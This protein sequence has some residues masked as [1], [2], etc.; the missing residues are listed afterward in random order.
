[1][2][3]TQITKQAEAL[4]YKLLIDDDGYAA[5]APLDREN[6]TAGVC[7][8]YKAPWGVQTTSYGS[9]SPETVDLVIDGLKRAQELVKLLN[10]AGL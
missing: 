6:Y 10:E 8:G 3:T 4:G 2:N 1:M 5:V 7:K 9:V